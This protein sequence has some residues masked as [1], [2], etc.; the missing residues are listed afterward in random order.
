MIKSQPEVKFRIIKEMTCRDNNLLN[1][2]WLCEIAG[3]S[4]SGY[5]RWMNAEPTRTKRDAQDRDDFE[6]VLKAYQYR[7]YNKG[8]RGIYM[9]LMHGDPPV[10]MNIKKIRR[11]MGKYHLFCPIRQA[12]PYRRMMRALR[13]NK[14]AQN[15]VERKFI[16]YG[17]R[18]ILLTDITYIPR[19]KGGFTYLSVITDAC[20]RQCLAYA[21]SD[22]LE[23]DFVLDTVRALV[24]IHGVTLNISEKTV[25]H[26]DQGSHYASIRCSGFAYRLWASAVHVAK[27]ELLGQCAAGELFRSYE[28]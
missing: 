12:N 22:S 1:I 18:R 14:V 20:T 26:S 24:S 21:C 16:I 15:I 3:V 2:Q 8:A 17:P 7:G 27:S 28:R 23:V 9:R 5:Y 19:S 25:F 6:H 4:R 10:I 13:T 11:L